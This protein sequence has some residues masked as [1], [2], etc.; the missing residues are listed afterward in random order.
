MPEIYISNR[1][2]DPPKTPMAYTRKQVPADHVR[3]SNQSMSPDL[4]DVGETASQPQQKILGL[5]VHYFCQAV[6]QQFPVMQFMDG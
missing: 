1:I 3:N 5:L 6:S 2:N 4:G